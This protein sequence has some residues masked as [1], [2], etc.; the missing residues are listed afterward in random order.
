MDRQESS[1]A[2]LGQGSLVHQVL[3][4]KITSSL[5]WPEGRR[6]AQASQAASALQGDVPAREQLC[7]LN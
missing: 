1:G 7:V 5:E 3:W 6:L 2:I 4:G